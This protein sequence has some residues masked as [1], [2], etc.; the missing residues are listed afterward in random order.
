MA[1]QVARNPLDWRSK[2]N[3]EI[4]INFVQ[5][6]RNEAKHSG[7]LS[8][9]NFFFVVLLAFVVGNSFNQALI[10]ILK[11]FGIWE[12]APLILHPQGIYQASAP[13]LK[14]HGSAPD[15]SVM[16]RNVTRCTDTQI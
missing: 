10:R 9:L 7:K 1:N 15:T 2:E 5:Y 4:E 14:N 11:Q 16:C 13:S 3:K 12:H 8:H 6:S